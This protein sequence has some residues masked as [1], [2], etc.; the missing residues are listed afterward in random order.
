MID[1]YQLERFKKA[2]AN[3]V[4]AHALAEIESGH[5]TGH[6]MWFIFPQLE[7]LGFSTISRFYAL[8]NA[9]EAR[10]YLEDAELGPGLRNLCLA[11]LKLPGSDPY[12]IFGDPDYLKLCSSMTL[13]DR[14]SPNDIFAKV[15]DKYYGGEKD[16]RTIQI[17]AEK[18]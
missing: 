9:S 5:K 6:W 15:L 8:K 3:G 12:E 7:G 2:Q 18:E 11:L 1:S 13:F 4:Y 10:A 17:L 16:Q 14:I